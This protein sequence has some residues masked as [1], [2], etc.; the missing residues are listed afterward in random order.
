MNL[1]RWLG[2]GLTGTAASGLVAATV[3]IVFGMTPGEVIVH[4]VAEMPDWVFGGWFKLFLVVVG[5]CLIWASLKFN[6]WSRR[7]K[8]VNELAVMLSDAIHQLLNRQVTDEAGLGQL[9]S[10]INHWEQRVLAKIDAYPA[11]F[12]LADRIHLERLGAIVH[13]HWPRAYRQDPQ[14]TRHEHEL[15]MLSLKFDRLRDIINWAQQ[16]TR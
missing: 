10:D 5:L 13:D 2:G 8:A 6:I 11:Y 7:Q 16:R 1:F 3:M 4:Q 9:R 14:D 12:S 15:N